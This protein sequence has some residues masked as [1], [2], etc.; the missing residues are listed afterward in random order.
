MQVSSLL[1]LRMDAIMGAEPATHFEVLFRRRFTDRLAMPHVHMP[2][3]PWLEQ[4]S[5]RGKFQSFAQNVSLALGG[6]INTGTAGGGHPFD[7]QVRRIPPGAAICPF[8]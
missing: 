5:P 4:R 1:P 2:S 6:S 8:H 3:L 7:V